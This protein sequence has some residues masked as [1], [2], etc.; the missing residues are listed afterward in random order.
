LSDLSAED[1]VSGMVEQLNAGDVPRAMAYFAEDIH[2][3]IIGFPPV[4]YE[5]NLGKEAF[6]RTWVN[7]VN[8]NLEWEISVVTSTKTE[9]G[10]TIAAD[11]KR[12]LNSYRQMNA[13]PIEFHDYFHVKDGRIVEYSRKLK[14]ESLTKL[15]E[16][17]PDDYF[18]RT[19]PGPGI[20]SIIPGAEF[21]ITF[22][23]SPAHMTVRQSGNLDS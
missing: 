22:Q 3:Y 2:G 13:S 23:I 14:P 10:T 17:L 9:S 15:R 21:D 6:C 8:D 1:V 4:V 18:L 5:E 16:T 11:S 20:S 12:W 19:E 7:Y